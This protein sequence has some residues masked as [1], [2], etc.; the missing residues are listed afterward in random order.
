MRIFACSQVT[1]DAYRL[2]I[3]RQGLYRR[4]SPIRNIGGAAFLLL[5]RYRLSSHFFPG[6][7]FSQIAIPAAIAI[8]TTKKH[9]HE[10][11][12]SYLFNIIGSQAISCLA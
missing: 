11:H 1:A 12:N 2:I 3:S 5:Y 8:P 10:I 6:L 9:N 4:L 7:V